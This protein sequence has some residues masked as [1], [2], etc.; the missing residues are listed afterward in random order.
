MKIENITITLTEEEFQ[1]ILK[2]LNMASTTTTSR[3]VEALCNNQSGLYKA[4]QKDI[5]K[6]N[7]IT[8]LIID[9]IY[10]KKERNK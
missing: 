1:T 3:A 6:N 2:A 5:E 10:S 8:E 7:N 9:S 4:Y